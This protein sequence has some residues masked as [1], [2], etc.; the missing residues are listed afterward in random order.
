[1]PKIHKRDLPLRIIVSSSGSPL[2]NL[3]VFLQKILH[4][5]LPISDS[6]IKNSSDLINRLSDLHIPDDCGLVSF[7]VVSLFTN[8]PTEI[9][10]D[11]INEKWSY[12]EKHSTLPKDEFLHAIKLILQSTFFTFNNNYY[13]QTFGT[14][15][16]SPFSPTIADLVLQKL[17]INVISE[18]STKPIFYY[19][20]IDDIVLAAPYTCLKNLLH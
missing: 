4:N 19:R 2:H 15:M 6:Y 8:A 9:F 5:S 14:P 12:I 7:D 16:G 17:E 1:L 18:I 3:A 20:Y 10:I 13:K 11:I